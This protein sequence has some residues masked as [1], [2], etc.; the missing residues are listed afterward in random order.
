MILFLWSIIYIFSDL[1][2]KILRVTLQIEFGVHLVYLVQIKPKYII[3]NMFICITLSNAFPCITYMYPLLQM[4]YM[5]K[6]SI[7]I[8]FVYIC[9][10]SILT[11]FLLSRIFLNKVVCFTQ[12]LYLRKKCRKCYISFKKIMW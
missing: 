3:L 5:R 2:C 12:N 8:I 9:E 10:F 1:F 6:Y 11:I 7:K 4:V